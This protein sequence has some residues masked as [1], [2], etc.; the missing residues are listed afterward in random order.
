MALL[1]IAL[2][3]AKLS[4]F[5]PIITTTSLHNADFVKS[6]GATHVIDRKLSSDRIVEEVKIIAGGPVDLA[7]DAIS[8]PDTLALS[9]A[10]LPQG[11]QFVYVLPDKEELVSR[12]VSEK[13]L[14]AVFAIAVQSLEKNR[15]ALVDLYSK[16][17]EY[18]EQGV[19]KVCSVV[20]LLTKMYSRICIQPTV[21][22]VLSGGL[23]AVLG[24]LK[25]LESGQ[26]S[27][28]KLVVHPHE[29]DS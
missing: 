12:L 9:A 24:G 21:P 18:L 28:V 8:E 29:T 20:L 19:I 10:V 3:F 17:P 5:G 22:E 23:K 15:G 14:K 26:V 2:Q 6:Y 16:L 11:G 27:G 1:R 7:Y 25:R 4:G 13:N